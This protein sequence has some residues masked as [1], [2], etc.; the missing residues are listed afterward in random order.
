MS[1]DLVIDVQEFANSGTRLAGVVAATKLPRLVDLLV[2]PT[3]KVSYG[4]SGRI[5]DAGRPRLKFEI[6]GTLGMRCQRCLS[7]VSLAIESRREV[8]FLPAGSLLPEVADEEPE[9][10]DLLMPENLRV[11]EWVEDEVLLGLPIAP[12]H[13]ED[14]CRPP[15]NPAAELPMERNPFAA[16][17][18]LRLNIQDQ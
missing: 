12:R 11:L 9:I 18:G 2:Q 10:D 1:E 6:T 16:L 15:V 5:D 8:R 7:P 4:V 13:E 14:K 17:S 3:A